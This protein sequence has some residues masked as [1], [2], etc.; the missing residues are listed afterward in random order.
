MGRAYQVRST[1]SPDQLKDRVCFT[2]EKRFGKGDSVV[3]RFRRNGELCLYGTSSLGGNGMAC[4][5]GHILP[6]GDGSL[7]VGR[8]CPPRLLQGLAVW[9]ILLSLVFGFAAV[10]SGQMF[11][12]LLFAAFVTLSG[13]IFLAFF[14]MGRKTQQ[15]IITFVEKNLIS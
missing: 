9:F 1:L 4:F 5:Y 14:I 13:I 3:Y 15:N 7:M 2:A 12:I 10:A 6:E 8:L 11:G